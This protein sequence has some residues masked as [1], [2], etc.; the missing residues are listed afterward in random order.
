MVKEPFDNNNFTT[1]CHINLMP[2]NRFKDDDENDQS[3]STEPECLA[4]LTAETGDRQYEKIIYKG[5]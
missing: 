3:H 2:Q 5:K 1:G 4:V